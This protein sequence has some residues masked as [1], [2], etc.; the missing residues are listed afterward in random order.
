MTVF[1]GLV[2]WCDAS[3]IQVDE[4]DQTRYYDCE[5]EK[6]HEQDAHDSRLAQSAREP[7]IVE[8]E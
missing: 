8:E 5:R 6:G 7:V 4:Q 1:H 3:F 2:T